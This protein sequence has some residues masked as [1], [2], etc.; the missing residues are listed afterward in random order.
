[1]RAVLARHALL[2]LLANKHNDD[3]NEENAR[4]CVYDFPRLFHPISVIR[5]LNIRKTDYV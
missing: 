4:F 5:A 2:A 1:M 3:T